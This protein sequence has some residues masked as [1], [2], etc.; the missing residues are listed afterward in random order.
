[1]ENKP[2][3]VTRP[4][5]PPIDE[6]IQGVREIWESG[7]VTNN[8]KHVLELE[9]NICNTL[10]VPHCVVYANGTIAL[11]AALS[12]LPPSAKNE[13]ITTPFTFA[14]TAHVIRLLG[15]KPIFADIDPKT[16]CL[17]PLA[18]QNKISPNTRAIMPVH[19]FDIPCAYDTFDKLSLKNQIPL[20]YDAAHSFGSTVAGKSTLDYGLMSACSFHATKVFNSVEGGC[21]ITRDSNLAQ[22]LKEFRNFGILNEDEISSIGINGKMS[23]LHALIGNLNLKTLQE[24]IDKR[25]WVAKYYYERLCNLKDIQLLKK[26]DC[27][28]TN[29]SYF[30]IL[31]KNQAVRQKLINRLNAVQ[32]YPRKYFYPLLNETAAYEQ[33]ISSTPIAADVASRI[34]CLPIHGLLTADNQEVICN[35]IKGTLK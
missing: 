20:V 34:L 8:G 22:R 2:V 14:A 18:V 9:K 6:V 32:V 29:F 4:I 31:L 30:P 33:D 12:V 27:Q 11:L 15:L 24:E 35:I 28:R 3:Y 23:E 16:L 26:P 17:D 10:K 13:I 5:L 7:I 25:R 19:C 21:V 1:M